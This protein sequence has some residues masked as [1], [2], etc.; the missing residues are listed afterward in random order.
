MRLGCCVSDVSHVFSALD[1][2][3]NVRP[4]VSAI[5]RINELTKE[6]VQNCVNIHEYLGTMA[7]GSL[8]DFLPIIYLLYFLLEL[9]YIEMSKKV[10]AATA[11]LSQNCRA[12]YRY[13]MNKKYRML[14]PGNL[15]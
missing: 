13:F 6:S 10:T 4:P 2:H 7:T 9:S 3:L 11:S 8:L 1:N 15:E 5:F 14:L 12:E